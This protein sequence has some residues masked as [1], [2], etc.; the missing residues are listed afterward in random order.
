MVQISLNWKYPTEFVLGGSD[1]TINEE[2]LQVTLKHLA[3]FVI[4]PSCDEAMTLSLQHIPNFARNLKCASKHVV[5][6]NLVILSYVF[7]CACL[8]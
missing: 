5:S 6:R 1:G 4:E 7:Q 3:S 2:L 8:E